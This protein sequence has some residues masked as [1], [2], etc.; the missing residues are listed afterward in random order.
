MN[1]I[2]HMVKNMSNANDAIVASSG[3]INGDSFSFTKMSSEDTGIPTGDKVTELTPQEA[4]VVPQSALFRESNTSTEVYA[5]HEKAFCDHI[6]ARF[7]ADQGLLP[8]S[9]AAAFS[10][11]LTKTNLALSA[12]SVHL[13]MRRLDD[14][15]ISNELKDKYLPEFFEYFDK[16]PRVVEYYKYYCVKD[17]SSG[18]IPT[19]TGTNSMGTYSLI[20]KDHDDVAPTG[21]NVADLNEEEYEIAS[22]SNLFNDYSAV[23]D[24]DFVYLYEPFTTNDKNCGR[25]IRQSELSWSARNTTNWPI[26]YH[27]TVWV[28]YDS[29][30]QRLSDGA[31]SPAWSVLQ[32]IPDN[33]TVTIPGPYQD[34]VIDMSALNDMIETLLFTTGF[35]KFPR[36]G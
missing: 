13:A 12:G 17:H 30:N 27:A 29:L 28:A 9:Q 2:Y 10:N 11:A 34:D 35:D 3:N 1:R 25:F 14:S 5:L 22:L 32:G 20:I 31:I 18:E 8:V 36:L 15:N 6:R 23:S 21:T 19:H 33:F 26:E 16:F 7:V 4:I 24:E